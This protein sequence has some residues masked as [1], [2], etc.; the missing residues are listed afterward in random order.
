MTKPKPEVLSE[1]IAYAIAAAETAGVAINITVRSKDWLGSPEPMAYATAT[2][3]STSDQL[4]DK[5]REIARDLGAVTITI[6]PK[7]HYDLDAPIPEA[8]TPDGPSTD[9]VWQDEDRP[10]AATATIARFALGTMVHPE[11]DP[12]TH[13][14]VVALTHYLT[15][16]EPNYQVRLRNREGAQCEEWFTESALRESAERQDS[17]GDMPA[18]PTR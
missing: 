5:L 18:R 16:M 15:G 13:G 9:R 2:L 7:G 10:A 11:M 17:D 4:V 6:T 3:E 1:S 12:H 14:K 8:P